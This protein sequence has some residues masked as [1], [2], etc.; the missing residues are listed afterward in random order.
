[1]RPLPVQNPSGR[2]DRTTVQYDDAEGAVPT[3]ELFVTED[4]SRSIL[5][6][7]DSPDIGFD[8]SVN[9]YRGCFH[10]CAYC[11][12]R[13][14]HEYLSMGAGTDFERRIVYKPR[15]AE[16]LREAFDKPSWRGE[17]IVFSGV[18]DCYQPLEHKL[19]LTRGC[20]EVCARY[21]N[22]VGIITKAPLIERDIDVLQEL[23]RVA[24][25][26]VTLSIPFATEA[27][28]KALEPFV[29]T[30]A[31]RFRT[32]ERL[33]SA[34]I[35]VGLSVA[36]IICGLNDTEIPSLLQRAKDAGASH[37]FYVLLRLPGPVAQVF[38]ERVKTALPLRA[39]RI[40]RRVRDTHG[41]ALYRS[42][43]HLRQRGQGA[44]AE[45]VARLFEQ[46]R[47]RLG[48]A[49]HE[50]WGATQSSTFVRPG[51]QMALF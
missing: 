13:P 22:P 11:Y 35:P 51:A 5:S 2:W 6:K 50:A 33:A 4:Q 17:L 46:S 45:M 19:R 12:A 39:E 32:M 43:F 44:H 21:R 26:R 14:G 31:R 30:S 18:T 29:T 42:D 23:A 15:A 9:P 40:L 34:G 37:A 16:L 25:V 47:A 49:G 27:Y 1:M 41:G 36:P 38:E 7:N 10:G 3:A 8:Y 20:L 28:A 24:K 48:I